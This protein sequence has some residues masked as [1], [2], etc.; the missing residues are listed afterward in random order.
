VP[1][2]YSETGANQRK[3]GRSELT[4]TNE[5]FAALSPVACR[6]STSRFGQISGLRVAAP[7]LVMLAASSCKKPETVAPPPPIVE[8]MEITTSEVPLTATLIG[9]L[10]S[11]QNVEVRA[12]VEAFVD[13]ML[14]T[15]GVEVKAG[16][17]LFELD[18][19]PFIEQLDA[20]KGALG[21]AN[22]ALNKYETDVRRLAPLYAKQ[23]IPKQ[24]L[25]N[26]VASVDVGKAAVITAEARVKAAELDLSYCTV[27]APTTGLIGAK[28]VSIGELVGK[29]EPTLLATISTLDPIWF[30][31]NVSEVDY[32]K[33]EAKSREAGKEIAK[34]PLNLVLSDGMENP[35]QGRFVFIDRAV[36]VKT[37]TL[38]IRAEFP[39]KKKL[40]RPGMFARVRVDLGTRKDT[41]V[42]PERA[43]VELQGKTFVWIVSQE[44]KANQRA[45]KVGEQTGSDFVILEGLKPGERIILEGLQKAREN[46]PVNPMTAAQ[47]AA[48]QSASAGEKTS[49]E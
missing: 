28:Q 36:D 24:D 22:A 32:F 25:D 33:A 7:L 14:F 3:A 10:D 39:N 17:V 43:L 13:E 29:G 18:R 9:Q 1:Q 30:Y 20:A 49:K 37:G 8:V 21:E 5:R 38:R 34:L 19:K 11:P 31:C 27:K 16:D 45:V 4:P 12:R 2:F 23:A 15:E 48:M 47:I 46:A 40:L 6:K 26:A 41:I 42:I 35:D 44:G